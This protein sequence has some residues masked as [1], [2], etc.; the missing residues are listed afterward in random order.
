MKKLLV[1]LLCLIVL[2]CD[3]KPVKNQEKEKKQSQRMINL[4]NEDTELLA[5]KYSIDKNML[6]NVIGDYE[7]LT[8][9]FSFSNLHR[10][11]MAL[12]EKFN[13]AKLEIVSVQAAIEIVSNKYQLSKEK[14]AS[15]LIEHELLD[16]IEGIVG[17]FGEE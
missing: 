17:R 7:N 16:D 1:L 4:V 3:K 12:E 15:I 11:D 2:G 13:S 5:I 10:K 8:Q 14:I 9:G 6:L